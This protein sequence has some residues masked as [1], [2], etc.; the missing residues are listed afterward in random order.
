[1]MKTPEGWART[2]SGGNVTF[3]DKNNIVRVVIQRGPAPT[4][5]TV[6]SELAG[7]AG[8]HV[9][10]EPVA[11]KLGS[12]PAVLATYEA[13]S[14]PNA[15]TGKR[16]TLTVDRYV[17]GSGGRRAVVDLGSP[18][19]VDNVDAYRLMITSFRLK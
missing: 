10:K 5:A 16:V 14:A 15:V 19:G 18:V 13:T 11:T 1:S 4:V 17:L 6:R 2:G 12:Q 3:R 7:L 9:T 8:A